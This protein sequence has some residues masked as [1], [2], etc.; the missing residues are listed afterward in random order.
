MKNKYEQELQALRPNDEIQTLE[1]LVGGKGYYFLPTAGHGYLII[2]NE[3]SHYNLAKDML[4]KYDYEGKHAIYLEE[5]T[6]AGTFLTS[7][8][9]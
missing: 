7:I 8:K 3:D 2:P 5:D 9:N 6:Q 1:E 4:S